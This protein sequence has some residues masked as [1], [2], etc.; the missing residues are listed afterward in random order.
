M[1]LAL[2]QTLVEIMLI[3][4]NQD[5]KGPQYKYLKKILKKLTEQFVKKSLV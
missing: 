2:K 1:K 5:N 3:Q 4:N